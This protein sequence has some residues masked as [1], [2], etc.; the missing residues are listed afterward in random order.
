MPQIV[1]RDMIPEDEYFVGSCSHVGESEETD[2]AAE[3]R[4]R[5]L[6]DLIG[7]GAVVKTAL[8]D[9]K[10]VGFA[11]SV[12]IERS[13]W[14]PI[15]QGLM[16]VPCLYVL[17]HAANK[18]IGR[19]LM[20]SVEQE[21]RDAYRLGMTLM[22][23]RDYP[24]AE[25]LLPVSFFE[26]IGY[27]AIDNRGHFTL[28]WKPFDEDAVPPRLL[29]PSHDF[30]PVPGKVVVDLFYNDFC[31]TSNIEAQ[32]VRE[33]AAEFGDRVILNEHC[34]DDHNVLLACGISRA[35]YVNGEEIGWGYEAPRD[36]IR[37]AIEGALESN[38]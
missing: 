22:G 32:R 18:G 24:G 38:S 10:H 27:T 29:D 30:R 7:K 14:G 15:G 6:H 28:L 4:I 23:F 31:Q 33:V 35:I 20:E 1:V 3:R 37:E 21:A 19:M 16:V 25:W 12:P 9:G 36:G 8:L 13:S 34:A 2:T 11:H 26:H 5:L 17:G